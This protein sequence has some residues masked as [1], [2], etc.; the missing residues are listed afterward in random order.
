MSMALSETNNRAN[1]QTK[2]S[3]EYRNH[4]GSTDWRWIGAIVGLSG[5]ILVAVVGSVLTAISWFAGAGSYVKT[6]GAVLLFLMIPLLVLG[7]QCLDLVE[8]KKDS[9]R[10]KRF[11]DE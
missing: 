5:G 2:P 7:A 11:G 3:L 9:E 8:K 6:I 4:G 1:G 10:K